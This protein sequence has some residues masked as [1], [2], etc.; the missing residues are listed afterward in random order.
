MPAFLL[1]SI[2]LLAIFAGLANCGTSLPI[3]MERLDYITFTKSK[4]IVQQKHLQ[5][6]YLD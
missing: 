2:S 5:R 4:P 6:R 1:T 3:D